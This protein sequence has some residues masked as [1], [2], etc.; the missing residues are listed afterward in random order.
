MD[1]RKERAVMQQQRDRVLAD[2]A[3]LQAQEDAFVAK[4]EEEMNAA[5]GAYWN[6]RRQTGESEAWTSYSPMPWE[7]H[8]DE[9]ERVNRSTSA[10][11]R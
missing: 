6:M 9:R 11:V 2:L 10:D 1:K 5:L 8:G 4:H 3:G 7:R